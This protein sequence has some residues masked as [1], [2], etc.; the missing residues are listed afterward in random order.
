M[1]KM[2]FG[3]NLDTNIKIIISLPLGNPFKPDEGG[4]ENI[5][6]DFKNYAC[7]IYPVYLYI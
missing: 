7:R 6:S 3:E 4:F 1:I 5:S 2:E